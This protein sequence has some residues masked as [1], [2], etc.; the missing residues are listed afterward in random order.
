MAGVDGYELE[1]SRSMKSCE[2]LKAARWRQGRADVTIAR[3]LPDQVFEPCAFPGAEQLDGVGAKAGPLLGCALTALR[4][5]R[6]EAGQVL[7][8]AEQ[9]ECAIVDGKAQAAWMSRQHVQ[10]RGA[11]GCIAQPLADLAAGQGWR[12]GGGKGVWIR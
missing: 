2:G 9:H 10:V 8:I 4:V 1:A 5:T 12:G 11:Q 3:R 6:L 7:F